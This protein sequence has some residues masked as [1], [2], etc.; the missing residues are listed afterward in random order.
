[1]ASFEEL[2]ATKFSQTLR[3]CALVAIASKLGLSPPRRNPMEKAL[4]MANCRLLA[5]PL[6]DPHTR[7]QL[8]ISS[9]SP[10]FLVRC[11][12][13]DS[14]NWEGNVR[15]STEQNLLGRSKR[16]AISSHS[17]ERPLRREEDTSRTTGKSR[18]EI[19]LEQVLEMKDPI[20]ARTK[21]FRQE[22]PHDEG[23]RARNVQ[24]AS[25]GFKASVRNL[26][27]RGVEAR[28]SIAPSLKD[29]RVESYRPIPRPTDEKIS[30]SNLGRESS[31]GD[32]EGRESESDAG[33]KVTGKTRGEI[34]LER[35]LE[36]RV[37]VSGEA[38]SAAFK[39]KKERARNKE[40]LAV[41]V[42][43][44][45]E[46]CCYGCGAVLQFSESE[47]PGFLPLDTFELV[48]SADVYCFVSGLLE[49]SGL[50]FS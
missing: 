49:N 31:S 5:G 30:P 17:N 9:K 47:A 25:T 13:S 35:A 7:L 23:A 32:S 41:A 18:G 19:F 26:D 2:L 42:A 43:R 46:P 45:S 34:F 1:M 21:S 39:A 6:F 4:T 28:A 37:Q 38:P 36:A 15:L 14:D 16:D 27:E 44:R 48:M 12:L 40:K 24:G 10:A 22:K 3:K 8:P 11:S 29:L 33:S 20:Q 50:G